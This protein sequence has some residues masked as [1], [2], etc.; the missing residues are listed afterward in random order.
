MVQQ[1]EEMFGA[2]SQSLQKSGQIADH[3]PEIFRRELPVRF[4]EIAQEGFGRKGPFEQDERMAGPELQH[5]LA[6]KLGEQRRMDR[7]EQ[8]VGNPIMRGKLEGESAI[9]HASPLQADKRANPVS[10]GKQTS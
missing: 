8:I 3:G 6:R 5:P 4:P 1:L 7:F 10:R 2:L 9:V